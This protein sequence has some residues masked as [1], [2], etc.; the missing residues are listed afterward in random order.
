MLCGHL[1]CHDVKRTVDM[2]A[3]PFCSAVCHNAVCSINR[4]AQENSITWIKRVARRYDSSSLSTI[5]RGVRESDHYKAEHVYHLFQH[6]TRASNT[7]DAFQL[8]QTTADL[9]TS[10][11]RYWQRFAREL[12]F[13]HAKEL[14]PYLLYLVAEYVGD[15]GVGVSFPQWYHTDHRAPYWGISSQ[16]TL[17]VIIGESPEDWTGITHKGE[18]IFSFYN[19]TRE[20]ETVLLYT[21]YHGRLRFLPESEAFEMTYKLL[22]TDDIYPGIDDDLAATFHRWC[23]MYRTGVETVTMRR[24]VKG[25]GVHALIIVRGLKQLDKADG[26]ES[27]R[28]YLQ[29]CQRCVEQLFQGFVRGIPTDVA[30]AWELTTA[31]KK[32]RKG[33]GAANKNVDAKRKCN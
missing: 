24:H 32:K 28:M 9:L 11:N 4:G 1:N 13:S 21:T 6:S 23:V 7:R 3:A 22:L 15:R 8:C 29:T 18:N 14:T 20:F 19:F 12:A 33:N 26:G 5:K 17:R 30:E 27:K 31:E 2:K 16:R 25:L 10:I